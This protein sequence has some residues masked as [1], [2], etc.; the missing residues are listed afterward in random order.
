MKKIIGLV[1]FLHIVLL[2]TACGQYRC[3]SQLLPQNIVRDNVSGTRLFE[4]WLRNASQAVGNQ[5]LTNSVASD[6]A[7]MYIPVVFHVIYNTAL[8]GNDTFN[9]PDSRLEEQIAILN[10]DFQRKSGTPG[11]NNSAIGANARIEFRFANRDPQGNLTD[12]IVRVNGG[13]NNWELSSDI[14]LKALSCWPT[15]KYLNVWVVNSLGLLGWAQYP[16][17]TSGNPGTTTDSSTDGV[18]VKYSGVGNAPN[19]FS[20]YHRGRTLTHEIGHYLGLLHVWGDQQDCS[21]NDFCN[22]TPPQAGPV[23]RCPTIRNTCSSPTGDLIPNYMQYSDDICMNM[24]TADQVLRM[25]RVLRIA[26]RRLSLLTSPG[27]V[28][29]NKSTLASN[30]RCYPNPASDKIIIE[31]LTSFEKTQIT[32]TDLLGR[33]YQPNFEATSGKVVVSV[34]ELPKGMY[35]IVLE[36]ESK[37]FTFRIIVK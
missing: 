7:L 13:R 9:I 34:S 35:F 6:S 1:L 24:F 32:F 27:L 15:D 20:P 17:A 31:G 37:H 2:Q 14:Q 28:L 33:K 21:G 36:N 19:I 8:S 30:I 23:E 11:F 16:P 10:N 22:D 26:P 5:S 3:G 4:S 12:G 18:V 25:R 29:S